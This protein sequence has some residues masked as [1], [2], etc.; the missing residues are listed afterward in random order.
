MVR[1]ILFLLAVSMT[2]QTTAARDFV[3]TD[4]G[5]ASNRSTLNT[6]AIQSAIDAASAAGG[7][8]VV[9]PAGVFRSG[10]IFLKPGVD[11]HLAADAILLG[12]DKIDDYPKRETRIE[13]HFEPWRLALI[14]AQHLDRVRITGPGIIDGNGAVFWSAFWQRRKENPECTNLE[15]ERPRLMFIDRCR[16]VRL[17]DFTARNSGFWNLHLYRCRDVLIEGVRILAPGAGEPI[18]APS[19]DGIDLDSCQDVVV[20]RCYI[21][22]D[23]DCIALKGSKG[24]FADRDS[25]SPP[26]ENIL[27]EDCEFAGGHGVLTCGSEATVVRRVTVRN[28][29]VVGQ[30][31]LVRL[32]LRPDTPQLYEDILFENI[33][34]SGEGRV[35]DINPWTQFFDLKGQPPPRRSVSRVTLR[36]ISGRFGSMG[37][38]VGNPG[39]TLENFNLE[40]IVLSLADDRFQRGPIERLVVDHVT[41]NGRPFTP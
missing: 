30:N 39:D 2:A 14:N 17:T 21:N 41:L 31:N 22:V 37:R 18:R 10:S 13:G 15:V 40:N 36:S 28:C 9:I 20:R 32:K 26:V 3:I 27:I 5:A 25:D 4:Y 16:D 6:P 11:L 38:I 33:R 12:S 23:D 19:S 7:G 29:L 24:P 34:L 1:S 8:R 35:F